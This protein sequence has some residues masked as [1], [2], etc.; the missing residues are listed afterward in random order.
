MH[1]MFKSKPNRVLLS[2][3]LLLFSSSV[4]TSKS[5]APKLSFNRPDPL[6]RLKS[7]NAA[8]DINNKHYWAVSSFIHSQLN[9]LFR[10]D[11]LSGLLFSV[12]FSSGQLSVCGIYG[13][14]WVC[15]WGSLDDFW[16]GIWDFHGGEKSEW[17]HFAKQKP[18][19]FLLL[20]TVLSGSSTYLS[21]NVSW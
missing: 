5:V 13:N 20:S 16:I 14:P 8:Y 19:R 1:A 21:R 2:L 6:K 17:R 10:I 18:P 11:Q 9:L 15:N 12:F 7:Y 4:S 3:I